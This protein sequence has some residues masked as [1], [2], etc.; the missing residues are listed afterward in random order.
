MSLEIQIHIKQNY[1]FRKES[2][3]T[4]VFHTLRRNHLF[5]SRKLTF[6]EVSGISSTVSSTQMFQSTSISTPPSFP[7]NRL[8]WCTRFDISTPSGSGRNR[9]WETRKG[10]M[11]LVSRGPETSV[12]VSGTP[13]CPELGHLTS[14]IYSKYDED[15]NRILVVFEDCN[16]GF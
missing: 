12:S 6:T 15:R 16:V 5:P 11:V 1:N 8:P 13:L 4:P 7:K 14:S 2:D 10:P 3:S 9:S